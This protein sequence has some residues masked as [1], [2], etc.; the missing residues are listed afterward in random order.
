MLTSAKHINVACLAFYSTAV[1]RTDVTLGAEGADVDATEELIV[2]GITNLLGDRSL[3]ERNRI[4]ELVQLR[5]IG[6]KVGHSVVLYFHCL[7]LTDVDR[8][9]E[10][11]DRDHMKNIIETVFNRLLQAAGNIRVKIKWIAYSF[12]INRH[13]FK[14]NIE[15]T[16]IN[17]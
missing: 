17:S 11:Y 4:L 15:N 13:F 2:K 7:E 9:Q 3:P 1:L 12:G 16:V 6:A 14:G 8:L 5:L 10:I